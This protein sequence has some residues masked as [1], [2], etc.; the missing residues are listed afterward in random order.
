V[1]DCH[2]DDEG[3]EAHSFEEVIGSKL[4]FRNGLSS[5]YWRWWPMMVSMSHSIG[6]SSCGE[7]MEQGTYNTEQTHNHEGPRCALESSAVVLDHFITIL[8]SLLSWLD[9]LSLDRH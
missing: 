6:S 9:S 4:F 1:E 2:A 7:A 8:L 5:I 3:H